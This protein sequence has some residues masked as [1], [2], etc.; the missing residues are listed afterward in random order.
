MLRVGQG[1]L[2]RLI[3]LGVKR[4]QVVPRGSEV[5]VHRGRLFKCIR[6]SKWCA[7]FAAFDRGHKPQAVIIKTVFWIELHGPLKMHFRVVQ[8]FLFQK[9]ESEALLRLRKR[10]L[11]SN[12]LLQIALGVIASSSKGQEISRARFYFRRG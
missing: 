7:C 9:E 8:F 12:S 11:G 3:P 5:R 6:S 4:R 10:W 1:L 2:Q